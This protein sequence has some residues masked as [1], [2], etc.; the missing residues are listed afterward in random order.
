MVIS[1]ITVDTIDKEF[2]EV[3]YR[4]CEDCEGPLDCDKNPTDCLL[5]EIK[6][7]KVEKANYG[8]NNEK[9]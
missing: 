6:M 4:Y 1:K 2:E 5:E 8:D 9:N 7:G 3:L